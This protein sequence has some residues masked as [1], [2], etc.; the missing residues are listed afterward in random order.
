MSEGCQKQEGAPV[1]KAGE[2]DVVVV[3]AVVAAAGVAGIAART[4][5]EMVQNS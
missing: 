3:V 1:L 5:V 2:E 4:G